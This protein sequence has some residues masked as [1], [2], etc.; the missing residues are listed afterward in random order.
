[1][2]TRREYEN[3]AP[4]YSTQP[5]QKLINRPMFI[6]DLYAEAFLRDISVIEVLKEFFSHEPFSKRD[7]G[8]WCQ[9]ATPNA[10]CVPGIIILLRVL[11]VIENPVSLTGIFEYYLGLSTTDP[12][13]QS[14]SWKVD[15]AMGW[16]Y[17]TL[18]PSSL[19]LFRRTYIS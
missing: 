12:L 15:A 6:H 10:E 1:M 18:L 4:A 8:R 3:N 9:E 2:K 19:P 16:K 11:E 7:M 17:G 13:T 14:M 5:G